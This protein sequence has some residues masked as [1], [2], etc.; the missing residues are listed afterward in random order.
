M[1]ASLGV[2]IVV[3]AR[4]RRPWQ[5]PSSQRQVGFLLGLCNPTLP[6]DK[7]PVDHKSNGKVWETLA[8]IANNSGGESKRELSTDRETSSIPRTDSG[9]WVYPSEVQFFAA[10]ARKQH[11]PRAED[12]KTIVPIHNVVNERAWQQVR[13]WEEGRG[14]EKCG[15]IK[16]VSFQG[17]PS[18]L[19]LRARWNTLLGYI[20]PA[21]NCLVLTYHYLATQLRLTAT[22]G[23]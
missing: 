17:K 15:G 6:M 4:R 5:H 23:W 19:S 20:P 7:C 14:G 2:Q 11:S 3:A 8:P 10:M 18:Q 9:N 1:P 21:N 16:L 13:D 22:I 12:M